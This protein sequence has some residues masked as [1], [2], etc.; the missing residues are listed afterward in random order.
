VD[1]KL[2]LLINREWT[3]P[4]LDRVMA[5]VSCF[6]VWVPFL[7]VAVIVLLI[8]GSFRMRAFLVVAGIAV[9]F[10]DGIVSK[11][12]KR[13]VDRPRPHQSHSNVRIVDLEKARPRFLALAKPVKVKISQSEIEDVEGRSFPSSHT[14]NTL[15]VAVAAVAFFGWRASWMFFVPIIVGYSRVYTG[16]HWPSDVL[17]SIF[18]GAGSTLLL[19]AVAD[20]IWRAC[21]GRF[22]R[23][24]YRRHPSLFAA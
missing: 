20:P 3:H 24:V 13:V 6:D 1:E 12:L 18:L 15:A 10:S 9:G 8:R 22:W 23:Q 17:T 19:L 21:G 2:L 7:V 11:V 14:M 5:A 4:A 16:S